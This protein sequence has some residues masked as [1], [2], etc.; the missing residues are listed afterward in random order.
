MTVYGDLDVSI[1]KTMPKDRKPILT[2]VAFDSQLI[3][4][5]DF[6]RSEIKKGRQAYIVYPLVEKSEKL[7]LKAATERYEH[8]S[9]EVFPELKCGLLHGQML[10][11]E[12]EDAMKAF[13][14]R[15]YDILVA[16]TVIEVGI[17]IPNASVMVIEDAERFGLS[18]LHQLRGRVGRGSE[19]SYCFLV[20]KDKFK[21]KIK[22]GSDDSSERTAA[23]VRLRTMQETNDG[24]KI[25][26]V[27]LKL[28]G[29]G[30]VLGTRQSGLPDFKYLD[31]INDADI[32]A[33]AK[34]AAS[35]ILAD[36][37]K[38]EMKKNEI[39]RDE[40]YKRHGRDKSFFN[41]A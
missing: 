41:I 38:L 5:L 32:I 35:G 34:K 30:D 4:V 2:K 37:P 18:Q 11:Y 21:F 31:L 29:P 15:E 8:L 7:E 23:I 1:I 9:T 36:D 13:L 12:K 25:S 39:I 3:E 14:S 26:E 17:D 28:R 20:T 6:L 33:I 27:D 24:F 19:Q 16:T 40:L 10:W 22:S